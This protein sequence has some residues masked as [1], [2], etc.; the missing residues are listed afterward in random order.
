MIDTRAVAVFFGM[1]LLKGQSFQTLRFIRSQ[2]VSKRIHNSW[3]LP[4]AKTGIRTLPPLSTQSWTFLRKSLSRHLLLSRTV[5]AY[6]LSEIRRSGRHLQD[7]K[8]WFHDYMIIHTFHWGVVEL[9][10]FI[11]FTC[12]SKLHPSVYLVSCCNPLC[13][14]LTVFQLLPTFHSL[15]FNSVSL[16]GTLQFAYWLCINRQ[17]SISPRKWRVH[18]V[19]AV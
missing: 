18:V 2:Y 14:P 7:K 15:F 10:H 12:Q 3:A 4:R 8:R 9:C 17:Y 6:V 19:F 11:F 13:R 16:L 1:I 5:V